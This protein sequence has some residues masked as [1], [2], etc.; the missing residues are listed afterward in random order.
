MDDTAL[1]FTERYAKEQAEWPEARTGT[2]SPEPKGSEQFAELSL[3][4][5]SPC[6]LGCVLWAVDLDQ[7]GQPQ[8]LAMPSTSYRHD[9]KPPRIFVLDEKGEWDDRGPLLW[10]QLPDG[11][12][13]H[14]DAYPRYPA[15]E[16]FRWSNPVICSCRPAICCLRR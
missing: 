15:K 1:S 11:Y 8:A 5:D 3:S 14:G 2:D 9:S 16:R 12:V 10:T 7:D 4:T 13:E 6:E